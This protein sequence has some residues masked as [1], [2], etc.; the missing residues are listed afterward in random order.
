MNLYL[1]DTPGFDHSNYTDGEVLEDISRWLVRAFVSK[2]NLRGILYLRRITEMRARGSEVN[3]LLILRKMCGP[4]VMRNVFMVTTMWPHDYHA[5]GRIPPE[6]EKVEQELGET[7]QLWGWMKSQGAKI[8]RHTTLKPRDSAVKLIRELVS[9][10]EESLVLDIQVEMAAHGVSCG[11]TSAGKVLE[12]GFP[13]DARRFSQDSDD[14]RK[15]VE[16][17]LGSS[18][19]D[20]E[21]TM[22]TAMADLLLQQKSEVQKALQKLERQH[23]ELAIGIQLLGGSSETICVGQASQR[24]H[25]NAP[26]PPRQSAIK[27]PRQAMHSHC[28][29]EEDQSPLCRAAEDGRYEDVSQMLEQ[30]VD[31]AMCGKLGWTALHWAAERGRA[32]I[33]ELL[34]RYGAPVN[35][36]SDTGAKPL[37]MAKTKDIR[38]LLLGAGATY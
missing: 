17:K 14:I 18:V 11:E 16:G 29:A 6:F 31:P 19:T 34:L 23:E 36:M 20:Q 9:P 13:K 33:V 21:S 37:N 38:R 7:P 28:P 27:V 35:A 2:I 25:P 12:R 10:E 5:T 8:K 24:V 32:N 26:P 15:M 4:K 3:S 1:I 22:V 30:G